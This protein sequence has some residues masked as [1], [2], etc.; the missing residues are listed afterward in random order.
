MGLALSLVSQMTY[1]RRVSA[2]PS[3]KAS[4]AKG[5][6]RSCRR[7]LRSP[8]VPEHGGP[9]T[10]APRN[11][12]VPEHGGPGT[13][14]S[15]NTAVPEHGG[16]GTRAR[17][18]PGY[19]PG[20]TGPSGCHRGGRAGW[21]TSAWSLNRRTAQ[22][23][24]SHE[25]VTYPS[26]NRGGARRPDS[27]PVRADHGLRRG[28]GR[29]LRPRRLPGPQPEQRRGFHRVHRRFCLPDRHAVRGAQVRVADDRARTSPATTHRNSCPRCSPPCEP[30]PRP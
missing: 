18:R 14:R 28:H 27:Y 29:A 25:C 30:A 5:E 15:R 3:R 16:P 26:A 19:C 10:R 2:H 17:A 6:R 21:R 13:R 7:A 23:A 22:G 4:P 20:A 9:G 1:E 8:G 24:E 11:T 12:A